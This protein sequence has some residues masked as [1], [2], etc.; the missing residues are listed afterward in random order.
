MITNYGW[1]LAALGIAAIGQFWFVGVLLL[2]R[3]I[4]ELLLGCIIACVFWAWLFWAHLLGRRRL[5]M[6]IAGFFLFAS[7]T[8]AVLCL[9]DVFDV[10]GVYLPG[11]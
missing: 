2:G 3:R 10:T 5:G 4:E 11:V 8:L 9:L 1:S 6:A 7:F